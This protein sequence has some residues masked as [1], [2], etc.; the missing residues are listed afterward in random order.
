M[1]FRTWLAGRALPGQ[2]EELMRRFV[3]RRVLEECRVAIPGFLGGELLVAENDPDAICVTVNWASR[4]DFLA[5]QASPVRAAQLP[6]L[7]A[8]MH[9]M[10]PSEAYAV[11]HG[12]L[13][14]STGHVISEG[15]PG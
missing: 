11:V 13:D 6:D 5:W 14:Q 12:V 2:R 3:E 4:E 15:L 1:K 9:S 10:Q 7:A 8:L